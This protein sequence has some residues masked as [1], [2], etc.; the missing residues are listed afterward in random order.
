MMELKTKRIYQAVDNEDGLRVLVDGLWPRGIKKAEA[1]IDLWLKEIAPSPSLRKWFH[2]TPEKWVE[3]CHHYH[4]ELDSKKD[5]L[6]PVFKAL[7]SENVTLLYS[8]KEEIFNNANA[9]K[10]YILDFLR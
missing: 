4:K 9:L 10:K 2:H 8:S 5:S 1:H 6:Q 3:F 7:K